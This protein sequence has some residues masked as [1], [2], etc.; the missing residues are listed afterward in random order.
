MTLELVHVLASV[1]T[2]ITGLVALFGIFKGHNAR[3]NEQLN[4]NRS[5]LKRFLVYPIVA[6]S[7]LFSGASAFEAILPGS[8]KSIWIENNTIIGPSGGDGRYISG[9]VEIEIPKG[10]HVVKEQCF[11]PVTNR[12]RGPE[13]MSSDAMTTIKCSGAH[14]KHDGYREL[15]LRVCYSRFFDLKCDE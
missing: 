12:T 3:Q 5:G 7:L 4:Q 6:L 13:I 11:F 14:R 10:T 15:I 8:F 2:V 9:S 1:V